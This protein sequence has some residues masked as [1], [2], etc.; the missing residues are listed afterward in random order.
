V[1]RGALGPYTLPFVD[2]S[3]LAHGLLGL[4]VLVAVDLWQWRGGDARRRLETAPLALRWAAW[5]ALA[6]AI[7]LLGV[8]T[9]SQF[10]YFQF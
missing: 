6:F 7:V 8:E 1:L 4:A 5:Y 2:P 3:T 9:G 10:I